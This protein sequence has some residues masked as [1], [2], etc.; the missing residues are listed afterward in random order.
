MFF[1][2][3]LAAIG[4]DVLSMKLDNRSVTLHIG[5]HGHGKVLGVGALRL[6]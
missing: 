4:T 5:R 1:D 3:V 2:A 6:D